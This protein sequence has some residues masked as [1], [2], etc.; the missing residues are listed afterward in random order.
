MVIAFFL[1]VTFRDVHS[2][3]CEPLLR[4]Q[5]LADFSARRLS[6]ILSACRLLL[7]AG[8]KACLEWVFVCGFQ[9]K[10]EIRELV[11]QRVERHAKR[12]SSGIAASVRCLQRLWIAEFGDF[13]ILASYLR[14]VA[15][16]ISEVIA[17]PTWFMSSVSRFN[18][19][20]FTAVLLS[21]AVASSRISR[22]TVG[23]LPP[24]HFAYC[25]LSAT[26]GY[27]PPA[28]QRH[29]PRYIFSFVKNTEMRYAYTVGLGYRV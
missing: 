17:L 23:H 28:L 20:D 9:C 19:T 26:R 3:L 2:C 10:A 27:C 13:L 14:S 24:T 18:L 7:T 16:P 5:R 21:V 22:Y 6:G 1:V 8:S 11:R 29:L 25:K 12:S 4:L 15:F